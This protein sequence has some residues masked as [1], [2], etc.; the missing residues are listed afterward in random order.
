MQI[1]TKQHV[2]FFTKFLTFLLLLSGILQTYLLTFDRSVTD[3]LSILAVIISIILYKK[4]N[5]KE[6]PKYF[7]LFFIV[8]GIS[9]ILHALFEGPKALSS[10]FNVSYRYLLYTML[11]LA[12]DFDYLVKWYKRIAII[13]IAFFFIQEIMFYTTGIRIL[14]VITSLPLTISHTVDDIDAWASGVELGKRSSSFFSEPAHF[15]QFLIPL[16]IIELFYDKKRNHYLFATLIFLVLLLLQSGNA[17]LCSVPVILMFFFKLLKGGKKITN[18]LLVFLFV[19]IGA[20][21]MSYYLSSAS[22]QNVM[23]RQDE[24]K[25]TRFSASSG[26]I[27]IYRGWYVIDDLNIFDKF[28][29]VNYKESIQ[30]YIRQSKVYWAFDKEDLYF[31]TI[32]NVVLRTGYI[33]S[34]FFLLMLCNLWRRNSWAGKTTLLSLLVMSFIS[35]NYFTM[36]MAIYMVV[37]YKLQRKNILERNN[38]VLLNPIKQ[39]LI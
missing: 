8:W 19:L 9:I 24:M 36:T 7:N 16:L 15:A 37:I 26:F 39:N 32:Q 22:G 35:A 18:M 27:R 33:G 29:G 1:N 31:N 3:I 38:Q 28:I 30:Q 2:P 23:E 6:V 12:I 14:G 25:N 34:L 17:L 13:C 10:I 4:I 20:F 11:F 5:Y 21:A